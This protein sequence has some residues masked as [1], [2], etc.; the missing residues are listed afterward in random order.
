[1]GIILSV[2]SF[3][4]YLIGA[5]LSVLPY[6]YQPIAAIPALQSRRYQPIANILSLISRY[7]M[8]SL[9]PPR[10]RLI[11]TFPS[12]LP[13]HRLRPMIVPLSLVHYSS[14]H[15]C[16]RDNATLNIFCRLYEFAAQ[17]FAEEPKA[18][19]IAN[20]TAVFCTP[21]RNTASSMVQQLHYVSITSR[22]YST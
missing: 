1:M 6:S 3:R 7:R 8:I 21:Q 13:S 2:S 17:L 18:S 11:A 15:H 5:I 9:L 19:L 16:H 20:H 12:P 14:L 4:Y 22:R 10:R